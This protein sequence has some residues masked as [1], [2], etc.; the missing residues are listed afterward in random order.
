MSPQKHNY[1]LHDS[2]LK[3]Y[4]QL[5]SSVFGGGYEENAPVHFN[6]DTVKAKFG[7]A[8]D[9]M[10]QAGMAKPTNVGPKKTDTFL[11]RQK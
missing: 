5:Q 4:Q 8:D 6:R 1:G 11:Q 10:T 9:W 2:K 7:T 3:K